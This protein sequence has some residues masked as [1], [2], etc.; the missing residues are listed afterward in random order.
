M[1][2]NVLSLLTALA[3]LGACSPVDTLEASLESRATALYTIHAY[4]GKT[5]GG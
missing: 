3:A 5:C 2:T 4:S 1:R